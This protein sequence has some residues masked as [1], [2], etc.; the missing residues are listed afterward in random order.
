MFFVVSVW[1][2][3]V[4][5]C[6]VLLCVFSLLVPFCYVCYE[7]TSS[8]L[9]EGSCL[10]VFLCMFAYSDVQHFVLLQSN[11]LKGTSI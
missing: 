5:F 1:L 8:C 6:V 3:L 9:W 11:L 4:V 10:I 7:F 2:I